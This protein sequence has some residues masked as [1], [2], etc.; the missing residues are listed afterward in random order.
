[1]LWSKTLEEV[2]KG[3]L[4]GPFEFESVPAD[5]LISSRFPLMQGDKL[6]PI[7]NYSSSLI[8]ET[9]TV[10]E[11]PV[12]HS[13]DEIALLIT[14]LSK[15]AKKKG[16][17]ELYGRTAD[18]KSAYR[19]LAIADTSLKFSFI[20]VYDPTEDKPKVFR[21]LAVPFWVDKSRLLLLESGES[22]LDYISKG[23]IGAHYKLFR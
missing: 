1:M 4:E 18:L 11:K 7:D 9:V 6:R 5:C 13:I 23:S 3:H 8:N 20:A 19:Q 16:L 14:K 10:S 21:Q 22:T 2:D 15:V 12:T 17:T